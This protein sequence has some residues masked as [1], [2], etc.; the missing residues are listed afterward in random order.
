M[1][2]F[3]LIF[4]VNRDVY[5]SV[6]YLERSYVMILFIEDSERSFLNEVIFSHYAFRHIPFFGWV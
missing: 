6:Y 3:S 4:C 5:V 1:F 2:S